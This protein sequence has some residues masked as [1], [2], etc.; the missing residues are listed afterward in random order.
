MFTEVVDENM[1]FV[2]KGVRYLM[3]V[4]WIVE[5]KPLKEQLTSGTA[6]AICVTADITDNVIVFL[7]KV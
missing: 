5:V 2:I 7:K 1:F 6:L 4:T 3:K